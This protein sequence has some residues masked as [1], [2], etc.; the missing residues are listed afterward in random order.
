MLDALE[1]FTLRRRG[2]GRARGRGRRRDPRVAG[3]VPLLAA[4][5]GATPRA[6][7]TSP[8]RRCSIVEGTFA[9]AVAP[10]DAAAVDLQPRLA[11]ASAASRMTMAA[12]DRPCIEMGS[13]RTHEEAAVASARAAY[14]AGFA[15]TS[16]L[17]ARQRYGVPSAGTS[18]HSFTLLHDTEADAFRAQV[19]SLGVGH[20]AAG[21]H[22]R[23][24]GGRPASASRSPAPDLGA[25]RLDSG[26]LGVLA[27]QVREQLD[28]ARRD[29]DPDRGD[30]RPRRVRHRRARG[31]ARRRLRRR[32]PAGHRQRRTRRA[33][34]STSW[35]PA[36]ATTAR[37]CRWPR[38]APTRS[39]SA[40]ASSRCAGSTSDGVA[41]AEV[42]GIGAPPDGRRQRPAAARRAGARRRGRRPRAARRRPRPGTAPSRA[43]LPWSVQQM[44][45]GEPVIPTIILDDHLTG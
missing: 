15:S 10:R 7:P 33:A 36:R 17:A 40:A 32:H 8:T 6:R 14:L 34:S 35:S 9:E 20:D 42:I 41:E 27:H 44:S 45:K 29:E 19:T 38:R 18:A 25:V 3:V 21:R 30:Q 16:N 43:E 11:I 13:R 31:R 24:R 5:S 22:L 37:W 1:E 39:R 4:T 23:R 2:A 26:D 12:G 28:D